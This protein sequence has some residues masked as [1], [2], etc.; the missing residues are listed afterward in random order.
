M[1]DISGGFLGFWCGKF[2]ERWWHQ[3]SAINNT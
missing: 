1:A 3:M 2:C